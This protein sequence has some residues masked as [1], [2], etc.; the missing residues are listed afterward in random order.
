MT[1][2]QQRLEAI[3][4]ALEAESQNISG[5]QH[6]AQ[7]LLKQF[8]E[9]VWVEDALLS[10]KFRTKVGTCS[11]RL[12]KI[13]LEVDL[14]ESMGDENVRQARKQA[15]AKVQA[16]LA[17]ADEVNQ[18]AK[19]MIQIQ[20]DKPQISQNTAAGKVAYCVHFP[21]ARAAN[22]AFPAPKQMRI[23]LPG[24]DQPILVE[25][26]RE[27]NAGKATIHTDD[28]NDDTLRIVFP[29]NSSDH[30]GNK[31]NKRKSKKR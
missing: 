12:E 25:L 22:V 6:E 21:Q 3:S 5:N 28:E 17:S 29:S 19:R 27:L 26:A 16:L 2:Q 9:Q 4:V 15:V 1:P 13:L 20:D 8:G 10:R 23:E 18:F 11:L 30:H 24:L 7:Q 31:S 14:V